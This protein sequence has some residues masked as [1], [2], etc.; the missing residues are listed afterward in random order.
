MKNDNRPT[1]KIDRTYAVALI[2]QL[3]TGSNIFTVENVK[4]DGSA[5]R[6]TICPKAYR[7]EIKG[8]GYPLNPLR[9]A[10]VRRVPD[11]SADTS[12]GQAHWRTLNLATVRHI[13]AEGVRFDVE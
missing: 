1:I 3:L 13:N 2:D 12:E 4:K 7:A 10:M 11:M 5:R 6:F 9:S 8:T